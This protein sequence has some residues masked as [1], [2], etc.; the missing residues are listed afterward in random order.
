MESDSRPGRQVRLI[1]LCLLV[2]ALASSAIDPIGWLSR[3]STLVLSIFVAFQI[4]SW[5]GKNLRRKSFARD[6]A[7][8]AAV[9]ASMAMLIESFILRATPNILASAPSS[10]IC[11]LGVA[12][13]VLFLTG[14]QLYGYMRYRQS[15]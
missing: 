3:A 5:L 7:A 14:P 12:T 11:L 8:A 4:G 6:A 10:L 13:A 1:A 15:H 2:A 9:L